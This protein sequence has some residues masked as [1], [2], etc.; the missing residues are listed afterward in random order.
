MTQ[1][2]LFD[3]VVRTPR[4]ELRA[5]R[6]P[7]M[8]ELMDLA[9]RGIH[10]PDTMPFKVGWTD[11]PVPERHWHSAQFYWG[12][13][14]SW[15]ADAWRLPLVVRDLATGAAVGVQDASAERFAA[16]GEVVT[17][18]W[19]GREL[20]G[21]GI[22]TEMRHAV[23]HLAFAG[24]GAPA[25][26]SGA[27]WDNAASLGVSRKLGY[28]VVGEEPIDRRGQLDR[29]LRLRLGRDRWEAIRR[30]DITIDG[31]GDALPLFGL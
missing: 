28:E 13:W 1:W 19:V 3:L 6:E 4:L 27:F 23:L 24:L 9:D 15:S 30:S 12:C 8:W 21:Q 10:D 2:P 17:G 26:R 18:S 29:C 11:E 5:V 20:Q 22:G 31:L 14:A 16:T 7:D 25:V